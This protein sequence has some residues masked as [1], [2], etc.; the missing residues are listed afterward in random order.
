MKPKPGNSRKQSLADDVA[1]QVKNN[2]I[3]CAP[4]DV[5]RR[6]FEMKLSDIDAAQQSSRKLSLIDE[7]FA[8]LKGQWCPRQLLC[9]RRIDDCRQYEQ[10]DD[11]AQEEIK[12]DK[13][14]RAHLK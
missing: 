13:T 8:A 7:F 2:W 5:F 11:G 6:G 14:N 3:V 9:P 4:R 10:S 12:P 1:G